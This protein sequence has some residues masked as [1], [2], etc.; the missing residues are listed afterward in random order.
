[1]DEKLKMLPSVDKLLSLP[2]LQPMLDCYRREVVRRRCTE[3][4]DEV[5]QRLTRG[6]L[7]DL[8]S[9]EKLTNFIGRL[10]AEKIQS[11]MAASLKPVINAA[12]VV[13]HTGLGRAPLSPV[14]QE[15]I[16]RVMQGYCSLEFDLDSGSRGERTDH[17]RRLLCEITGAEDA[18]L[19]NNNAAAVFLALNTLAFGK[20]AIISR[21]QLIEIGG[22]FRL[23]EVMEKSGVIM[24]EVGTT[25]KTRL[26]DYERAI[27]ADTGAIVVAHTSN[28]RVLGFT[29]EVNLRELCELA[30]AHG[31]PLLHDLGAG[32]LIDFKEL[33]LPHEPLVQESLVA[34]A[35]VV[36]FSGD[37]VIGG[38]QSGLIVGRSEWLRKIHANPIMRAVRCDKLIYAGM[39]ATLKLFLQNDLLQQHTTLRLLTQSVDVVRRRAEALLSRLTVQTILNLNVRIEPCHGQFGSGA[40]P[41]EMI[42]SIAVVL[43]PQTIS[44]DQLARHLRTD[45]PPVIG[46]IQD[47]RVFLDM[48]TVF[49]EQVEALAERIEAVLKMKGLKNSSRG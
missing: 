40:L 21:G 25:N 12:G 43:R 45:E 22:S 39:E 33:G 4:L 2:V 49:D 46:Y 6:D 32:V 19:V 35:D 11:D 41:L 10:V 47:D 27:N 31:L 29:N 13:L 37:K 17:V 36:T 42:P 23:P 9:R 38:P 24:R 15:N 3:V 18:L 34:G 14:A 28:Y 16:T 5:R 26:A 1:M 48:R 20:E 44:A 8:N 7:A 30:H